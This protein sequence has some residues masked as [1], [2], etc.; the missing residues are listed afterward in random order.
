MKTGMSGGVKGRNSA[1]PVFYPMPACFYLQHAVFNHQ[2]EWSLGDSV[3]GIAYMA[4]GEEAWKEN[5]FLMGF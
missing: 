2:A 1:F 5:P 4:R 3:A